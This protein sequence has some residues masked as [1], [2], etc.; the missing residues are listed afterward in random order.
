MKD[1]EVI[2]IRCMIIID[3]VDENEETNNLIYLS[4]ISVANFLKYD[5][6]CNE[7]I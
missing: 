4:S 5:K 7:K 3:F 6:K 1:F 2:Q